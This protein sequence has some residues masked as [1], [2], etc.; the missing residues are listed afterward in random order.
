MF[1]FNWGVFWAV[2]A[3][4]VAIE[5]LCRIALFLKSPMVVT[6]VAVFL[7]GLG[8]HKNEEE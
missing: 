8:D 1:T 2:V 6:R 3:A 7:Y 4:F 5:V